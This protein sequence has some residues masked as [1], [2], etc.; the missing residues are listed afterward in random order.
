MANPPTT[1]E[2]PSAPTLALPA[3]RRRALTALLLLVP[4]PT[5]GVLAS[6]WLLPG[7]MIGQLIYGAAKVWLLLLPMVWWRWVERGAWSWSPPRRGGFAVGATLG[8]VISGIIIAGYGM[9]GTTIIDNDR[10]QT[11]AARNNL[12]DPTRYLLLAAYLTLINAALEEY[13][14]RWFVFRQCETVLR[15]AGLLAVLAAAAMFTLH[16]FIALKLQFGWTVTLLGSLG[17]FI[18]GA[19]WSWLYLRYRSIW[20]AY[21][22]HALVDAAV[23]LVGWWLLFGGG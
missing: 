2:P 16:H 1:L 5:V 9:L 3:S 10:L 11:V 23:F 18:G 8:L 15:G 14:W 19:T 20:P 13:V 17:V 22:S 4:A 6:L 21:L 7:T 12:T